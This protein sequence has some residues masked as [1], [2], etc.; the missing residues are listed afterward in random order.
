MAFRREVTH[1]ALPFPP[2]V[3]MHDWWIGLLVEAKGRVFFHPEP[4]IRYVRHGTNA[5]P[6]GEVGYGFR[7]RL[8]NRFLLLL[9][10]VKRLWT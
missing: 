5:S 7:K 8:H 1:Y 6:T 9:H 2:Q 10:I 3:H 4:L